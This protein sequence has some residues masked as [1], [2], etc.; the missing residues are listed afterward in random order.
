M[1]TSPPFA[2]QKKKEYGNKDQ[3]EYNEWFLEFAEAAYDVLT[4]DGSF[5]VDIGGG[6]E[7]GKPVRSLYHFELLTQ[8]AGEDGPFHLAQDFYWYNPAKLPT[9]AQWVTIERIRVKDAVNHVWVLSKSERPKADNRRVLKEYSESQKTLMEEGYKDKKRPSGHD[10]SDTFDDPE[11]AD[12]AIR[13]NLWNS[14]DSPD[15]APDFI[16]L[17]QNANIP[18]KLLEAAEKHDVL[19]E[20]AETVLSQHV[21]DNVLELANTAS[22]THYLEACRTA[23][24]E[25]HPARFPRDLPEFFIKFLSEPGDTVLD[26]FAGS[27]IT[28]RVAQDLEREWLAF[29]LQKKYLQTSQFRFMD[30]KEIERMQDEDQSGMEDFADIEPT[31]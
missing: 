30:I 23:D 7:K 27:N 24:V 21:S 13:P 25:P 4:E 2:L 6:W 9:P 19:D 22:N 12:G 14:A 3:D 15:Y 31:D 10:I 17:L 16:E 20:L 18:P 1:V 11:D 8:L 5:V 29:E 26:I 28:G